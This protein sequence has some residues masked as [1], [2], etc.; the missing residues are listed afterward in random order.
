MSLSPLVPVLLI[1]CWALPAVLI[2]L[3]RGRRT[4]SDEGLSEQTPTT[5]LMGIRADIKQVDLENQAQRWRSSDWE[6]PG[7]RLRARVRDS[8]YEVMLIT[9]YAETSV[10]VATD[11]GTEHRRCSLCLN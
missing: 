7:A 8:S 3:L 10:A 9:P 11:S 4:E 5:V 6:G 1:A 2:F